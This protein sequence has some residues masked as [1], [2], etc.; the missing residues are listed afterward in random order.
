LPIH[1]G[2]GLTETSPFAS[3]NHHLRHKPGSVGTPIEGVEMKVVALDSGAE[4]P[5]GEPGEIVVRG[6]NVMLGYWRQPEET[7]RA[8]RD[9]WFHTG[10]I[11]SRDEEGYY[12]LHDRIKDMVNVGGLKVYPAEVDAVLSAYPGVADAA[13]YGAADPVLG[14]QLQAVV[15][16]RPGAAVVPEAVLRF[17]QARLAAYKVPA[18]VEVRETLPRSPTGKVLRRVLRDEAAPI[19]DGDP[20]ST[21]GA[22]VGARRP[23]AAAVRGWIVQWLEARLGAE[24]GLRDPRAAFA[25]LGVSSVQAVQ[26]AQA[27]SAR[28]GV[29]LQPTA[30]WSYPT[31]D[32][33]ARHVAAGSAPAVS[34][35]ASGS[36]SRP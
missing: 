23:G 19:S 18:A 28:F 13:A 30:L 16:P 26:L 27:L 15:V 3:Y 36:V 6:H 22:G 20:A 8:I 4:L 21:G 17:C 7:A 29:A 5:P 25:D 34:P 2:Y 14:E 31:V 24:P 32:G 12:Y 35:A 33:L 1:Q 11:G 9:G 10:D